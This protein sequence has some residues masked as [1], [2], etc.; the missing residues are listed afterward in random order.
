[1]SE[2]PAIAV[3]D[4][5]G[6]LVDL[7]LDTARVRRRVDE[8]LL[9][10]GAPLREQGLVAGMESA[11]AQVEA[12]E[13]GA[14][15]QL[16][17]R[18][19]A[20]VDEEE[21]ERAKLA[22]PHPG[23]HALLAQLASLPIALYTNNRR[24]VALVALAA[25]GIDVSRFFAI[26]ARDGPA[27]IKPSA[28]PLL[29]LL[30]APAASGTKRVFV[31]GDH[32][33]DMAAAQAARTALGTAAPEIVAIGYAH[34]M[35]RAPGLEAAGA[36]FV[37]TELAEAGRLMLAPRSPHS[38]SMVVLA[39]DEEKSIAAA[40]RECRRVGRL[41]LADY[42]I[43]VIDDGS[44]DGT[45]AAAMSAS[46]GDVRVIRHE[47]NLGMGAGMRDGYAAS[48]CDY[49]AHLPGDRQVRAQALL[50][51]LPLA[52]PET[53]VV[54]S[55]A[56]PPSGQGRRWLSLAFRLVSRGLG[57]L[58]VD[59]AGTYLFHR[60]WLERVDLGAVRSQSFLFSF[61]LLEKLRRAGS[62]FAHVVIRPFVREI[63]QS[64]EAALR[65]MGRVLGEIV[66]YRVREWS[67]R[68]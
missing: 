43:I 29:A 64:R 37:V 66:R 26:A 34:A 22:R 40:V 13:P 33:A 59:F 38:L 56:A 63:G 3:L 44:T 36:D 46:E 47:R 7:H 10:L 45:S 14:G 52:D 57:G 62:R 5:D 67:S 51:F 61:E 65:R 49:I 16:A 18:L 2:P 19:W 20:I 41:W 8:V 50:A 1:M 60:R 58:Q 55:Y 21:A 28:E 9:P 24:D 42:E 32:A 23:A 11:C 30:A 39:L 27:S 4:L 17:A 54:S 31:L 35:E 48:R 15:A 25:A 6:V 12:G 68:A 53:T